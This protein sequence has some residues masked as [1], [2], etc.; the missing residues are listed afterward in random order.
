M[1]QFVDYAD[2]VT[3]ACCDDGSS[4]CAGGYPAQCDGQCGATLLPMQADCSS[5]L[6]ANSR[7]LG[8]ARDQING[9]ASG[10]GRQSSA[11][12]PAPPP[13]PPPPPPPSCTG[14]NGLL[15]GCNY[16][17]SCDLCS[18]RGVLNSD[19]ANNMPPTCM[20]DCSGFAE[21]EPVALTEPPPPPCAMCN[22]AN[23]ARYTREVGDDPRS[24]S[25]GMNTDEHCE[26]VP[27]SPG[28]P[29]QCR[30]DPMARGNERMA[31]YQGEVLPCVGS[32]GL[33]DNNGAVRDTAYGLCEPT[34]ALATGEASCTTTAGGL[35]PAVPWGAATDGTELSVCLGGD[36]T[37][38]VGTPITMHGVGPPSSPTITIAN[39]G[40][41]HVECGRSLASGASSAEAELCTMVDRLCTT[42][43]DNGPTVTLTVRGLLF[44]DLTASRDGGAI[45]LDRNSEATV[46]ECTFR[47]NSAGNVRTPAPTHLPHW[48]RGAAVRCG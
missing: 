33:S 27:G 22:G 8:A 13:P 45:Y 28:S 11:T 19:D 18:D 46:L 6:D 41:L 35:G 21:P 29:G 9:A 44:Q 37:A 2:A 20:A 17:C 4:S 7:F 38:S 5:F 23:G 31:G 16:D 43:D 3:S 10:C 40:G 14:C 32:H 48:A 47:R 42:G 39:A 34:T 25:W 24:T 15:T 12:P 36:V 26:Y 1:D 30:L